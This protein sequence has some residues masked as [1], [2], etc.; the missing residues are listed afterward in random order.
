VQVDWTV[1]IGHRA[2]LAIDYGFR[3]LRPAF[4][5]EI[6]GWKIEA[7]GENKD[8]RVVTDSE[9]FK[10]ICVGA[11]ASCHYASQQ[12]ILSCLAAFGD[13]YQVAEGSIS[14]KLWSD[15]AI[16][17]G[18]TYRKVQFP[19]GLELRQSGPFATLELTF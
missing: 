12:T 19:G 7:T 6:A 2:E 13:R 4:V 15:F 5:A 18:Y 16:G 3:G 17:G 9:A 11:G 10:R 8:G 1:P 14:R